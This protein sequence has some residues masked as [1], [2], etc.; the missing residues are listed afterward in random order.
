MTCPNLYFK[1]KLASG[2]CSDISIA[3]SVY[4]EDGVQCTISV[5]LFNGSSF[6]APGS[7]V[8]YWSGR[9]AM[10]LMNVPPTPIN[11]LIELPDQNIPAASNGIPGSAVFTYTWQLPSSVTSTIA[12]PNELVIFA[13]AVATEVIG[14]P[15]ACPGWWNQYNYDPTQ[16]FNAA[17]EFPYAVS[18]D[19]LANL[20]VG[21][22]L[23]EIALVKDRA[24]AG[25]ARSTDL[26]LV[27]IER[28]KEVSIAAMIRAKNGVLPAMGRDSDSDY[29][30]CGANEGLSSASGDIVFSAPGR[31]G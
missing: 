24:L 1:D 3:P 19:M 25:I 9:P 10:G 17:Q 27:E 11:N 16:P 21:R 23:K 13:Q 18:V 8:L 4:L 15:G 7:V 2:Y 26:A 14:G 12:N 28:A 31:R 6:A 20:F 29:P 22:T 5:T 30:S